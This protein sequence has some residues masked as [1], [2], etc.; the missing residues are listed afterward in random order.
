L[1]NLKRGGLQSMCKD[2]GKREELRKRRIDRS[3]HVEKERKEEAEGRKIG[4][5]KP[6]VERGKG[7]PTLFE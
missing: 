1:I 4:R 5:P 7:S 6:G 2:D 3:S